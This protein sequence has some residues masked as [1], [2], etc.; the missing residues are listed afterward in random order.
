MRWA[1]SDVPFVKRVLRGRWLHWSISVVTL[2]VFLVVILTGIFGT[3]AGNHN[4]GIVYV[5]LVW[6]ALLKIVLV[7]FLGR[8]WCSVCPIPAPGE[9]LQRRAMIQPCL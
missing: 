8:F 9:W 3:P 6:W 4:F 5:W 1:V 7:P 2:A